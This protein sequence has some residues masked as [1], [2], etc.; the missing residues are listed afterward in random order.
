[1]FNSNDSALVEEISRLER[2]KSAA[3]A[4]QARA[5]VAL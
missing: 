1:M 2:L 4:E 5:A 3:A